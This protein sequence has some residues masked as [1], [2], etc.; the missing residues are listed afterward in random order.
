M[1]DR[2]EGKPFLRLLDS[3]VLAA[4]GRLDDA[5]AQWLVSA[6]PHFRATYGHEGTWQNIVEKRMQFPAGMQS[7]I[8]ET[9]L[10]GRERYTQA[11]GEEPDPVQFAHTFVDTNFPH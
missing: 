2:Y 3:Y 8:L 11:T 6:E 7:A 10:K 4:I 5:N 9:W 1:S